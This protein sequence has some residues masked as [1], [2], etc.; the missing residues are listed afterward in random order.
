MKTIA[1]AAILALFVIGIAI[2]PSA[3]ARVSGPTANGIYRF[4]VSD[5]NLSKTVE[6]N[7]TGDERGATGQMTY[8]DTSGSPE[9]DPDGGDRPKDAPEFYMTA[10]LDSLKIENNRAVMGGTIRDSSIRSYIG[11]WV[12]LVVEDNGDGSERADRLAWCFC[13]PEPG[14]W[15]PVDAE[16]PHDDGAFMHWWATDA[17][18][19]EDVGIDSPNIIPGTRQGCPAF[20][21]SSYEFAEVTGEGQIVVQP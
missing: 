2:P 17:E 12:Q 10:D 6:F 1:C 20:V 15:V 11:R 14:G 19:R 3:S 21:L 18:V 13:E 4:V 9:Y 7:A 8:R 16:D 5:D